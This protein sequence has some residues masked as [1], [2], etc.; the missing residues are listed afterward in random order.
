MRHLVPAVA[1][2]LIAVACTKKGEKT[3]RVITFQNKTFRVESPGGCKTDS[4]QCAFYEVTYP[5]FTGLDTA[6][7]IQ[8]K[9]DIDGTVSMGNPEAEGKA[10]EQ[11]G[12]EFVQDY[13]DFRKESPD[14]P[15][16]WYYKGHVT[17]ET[18]I[19]TLLSLS[20]HEEYYAGAAHGSY[21]VYY[22]NVNP[23]TGAEFTLGHLLRR[24]YQEALLKAGEKAFRHVRNLADTA[25]LN[26][27]YFEFTDDK[28]QLNQN[29]GF[30]K[31]GIVF[32]Y[33]NYEIAAFATG[34]TEILIPYEEI[35]DWLK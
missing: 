23:R 25:S 15:G 24:G 29:Y 4:L 35:K 7:A 32:Y 6:V 26:A 11:I 16:G 12:A 34:P 3:E 14:V 21:G 20:V 27:N 18:L 2:A 17:V 28:F 8:L 1:L 19:D 9:R 22:I 5:I 30:K 33:N 13:E 31:E 10:M